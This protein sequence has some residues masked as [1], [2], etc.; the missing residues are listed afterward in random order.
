MVTP[1]N[2]EMDTFYNNT[3]VKKLLQSYGQWVQEHAACGWHGYFLSFMFSQIPG[4]DASRML[5]M[6]KH[7]G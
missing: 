6:K 3:R 5:E 7:L 1:N 2:N 4:S